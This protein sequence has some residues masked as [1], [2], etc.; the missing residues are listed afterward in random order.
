MACECC[1]ISAMSC[2]CVDVQTSYCSSQKSCTNRLLGLVT[3]LLLL[4]SRFRT[5]S[6]TRSITIRLWGRRIISTITMLIV[7]VSLVRSSIVVVA[8]IRAQLVTMRRS[9][10]I[11]A[12]RLVSIIALRNVSASVCSLQ[13]A[14]LTC[15][16]GWKL[17]VEL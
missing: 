3:M 13:T 6:R 14:C 12:R 7:A 17:A 1:N 4:P 10:T 16:G 5:P 11:V 9:I 15:D 2:G 8:A